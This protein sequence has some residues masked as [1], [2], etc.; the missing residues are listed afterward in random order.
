M[1]RGRRRDR[2]TGWILALSLPLRLSP[3]CQHR[4]RSRLAIALR[5]LT[6]PPSQL[7]LPTDRLVDPLTLNPSGPVPRN[8]IPNRRQTPL[9][10]SHEP[11]SVGL[12]KDEAGDDAERG[13]GGE[14]RFGGV[15][16][17][18]GGRVWVVHRGSVRG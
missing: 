3:S 10:E 5:A 14:R 1:K 15:R 6:R 8:T 7:V 16:G 18:A 4:R 2:L 17:D 11:Q 9:W 13:W 12:G